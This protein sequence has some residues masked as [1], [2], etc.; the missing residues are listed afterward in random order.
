M[1]WPA[2]LCLC[3]LP[4]VIYVFHSKSRE[5]QLIYEYILLARELNYYNLS[6]KSFL[7]IHLWDVVLKRDFSQGGTGSSPS[8][9]TKYRVGPTKPSQ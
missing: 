7:Q 5:S 9:P 2:A 1:L 3:M 8:S 4:L 6:L